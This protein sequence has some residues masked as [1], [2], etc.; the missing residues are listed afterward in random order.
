MSSILVP[1]AM[2]VGLG[3]LF[4]R[5]GRQETRKAVL[6]GGLHLEECGRM[7]EENVRR[8]LQETTASWN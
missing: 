7:S 6:F 5:R 8:L 2:K 3:L 4:V 1:L